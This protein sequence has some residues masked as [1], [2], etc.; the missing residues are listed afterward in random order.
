MVADDFA[1]DEREELLGELRVEVG[2]ERQLT[3]PGDLLLFPVWISRREVVLGLESAHPL[4]VL[5]PLG[6]QVNERGIDVV[7][8]RAQL[9]EFSLR[10]VVRLHGPRFYGCRG[11]G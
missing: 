8:A 7:D 5:E 6:E 1:D 2:V 9:G 11:G 4:R 10:L 3:Q